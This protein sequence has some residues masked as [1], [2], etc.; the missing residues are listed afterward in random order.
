MPSRQSI[1][2]TEIPSLLPWVFLMDVAHDPLT[3]RYRLIGTGIVNFL[4]RDF[5]GRTINVENYGDRAVTMIEI[6][7]TAIRRRGVTAVR[8]ALFYVPFRDFQRF[9]W[10]MMPL[11]TDGDTIDMLFCGYVPEKKSLIATSATEMD[12]SNVEIIRDPEFDVAPIQTE[13]I[14]LRAVDHA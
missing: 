1:D 11:S 6:F 10:T 14:D 5:T 2:P 12:A 4:G 3:F 9:C 7:A 8:G 13:Q